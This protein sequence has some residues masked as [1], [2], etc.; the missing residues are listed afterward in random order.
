MTLAEL[1]DW[2][3]L[4]AIR[5]LLLESLTKPTFPITDWEVGGVVRTQFEVE[6]TALTDLVEAIAIY[7]S[8]GFLGTEDEPGADGDWL[9]ALAHGWYGLD[10]NLA[11]VAQQTITLTCAAGSGPYGISAG[12]STFLATDGSRYFS[13]T[14]GALSNGSP[15]T[16]DVIAE[17]PGAARGLVTSIVPPLKGVTI[18]G[19]G[20][21]AIAGVAQFGADEERDAALFKRCDDRWPT[22]DV[23]PAADDRLV[24]WVKA[25]SG[26]ITRTRLDPDP[27]NPGGVIVTVAGSAGPVSA[28]VIPIAQAY[29]DQ[30]APITDWDMVQNSTSAGIF[31]AGTVTVRAAMLTQVQAAADSAWKTYLGQ[32]QIGSAVFISKLIQ[33]VMDA[34]AIDFV[35][36]TL[37]GHPNDVALT[38][39]QVPVPGGSG[40]ALLLTWLST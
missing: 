7:V 8:E 30:R 23:D 14:G 40:L 22:F 21:K 16:M 9:T 6:A 37:N 33:A 12:N 38:S 15:L 10:R 32:A 28:G 18:S 11:G 29:V 17:S 19:Q 1:I 36:P 27:V 34:G 24:K 5:A 13:L 35:S 3:D 2:P 20:I 39:T 25:A 31:A 4:D 26:E